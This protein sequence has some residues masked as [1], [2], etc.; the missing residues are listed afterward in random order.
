MIEWTASVSNGTEPEAYAKLQ[1]KWPQIPP[2]AEFEELTRKDADIDLF[3]WASQVSGIPLEEIEE[4]VWRSTKRPPVTL[5]STDISGAVLVAWVTYLG[6]RKVAIADIW[7]E[8]EGSRPPMPVCIMGPSL[9]LVHYD[10]FFRIPKNYDADYLQVLWVRKHQYLKLAN[11]FYEQARDLGFIDGSSSLSIPE[12]I[13]IA[14]F[15]LPDEPACEKGS[16]DHLRLWLQWA[17]TNIFTNNVDKSAISSALLDK[18]FAEDSLDDDLRFAW[19]NHLVPNSAIKGGIVAC[20]APE[21]GPIPAEQWLSMEAIPFKETSNTLFVLVSNLSNT[22]VDDNHFNTSNKGLVKLLTSRNS[23]V[24]SH[25]NADGLASRGAQQGD[26]EIRLESDVAFTIDPSLIRSFDPFRPDTDE[27]FTR[28]LLYYILHESVKRRASDIHIEDFRNTTRVRLAIDNSAVPLL[29]LPIERL[30]NIAALVKVICGVNLEGFEPI[31]ARFAFRVMNRLVDVRVS[32]IHAL[33]RQPK[34]TLRLLDKS[35]N[36]RALSELGLSDSDLRILRK[37]ISCPHG[38]ILVS[39][40]TGSGKSTTLYACI[41][42][43]NTPENII[44]TLEDP[45]E[46]E[47]PGIIQIPATKDPSRAKGETLLFSDGITK[48]L[49]AD[50]T[51]IMVGEIRDPETARIA[52]EAANTGHLLVST[53]HANNA[54]AVIARLVG[55]NV[56]RYVLADSIR[57]TVAQRLLRRLCSCARMRTVTDELRE[58]FAEYG[59]EIP[60]DKT[61]LSMPHGCPDCNQTGYRGRICVMEFLEITPEVREAIRTA[62]TAESLDSAAARS[63]YVPLFRKAIEKVWAGQTTLEEVIK[64]CGTEA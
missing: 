46:Y 49:R 9:T 35:M 3:E 28:L 4:F 63:G 30:S 44:Y 59:V 6:A 32:I 33:R 50:P 34:L 14:P 48:L 17:R 13:S 64:H 37:A 18:N 15:E 5:S 23:I 10:P 19:R 24:T 54:K 16:T 40:P 8:T 53:V 61:F 52:I 26:L 38:I 39:G 21:D 45:I 25:Q 51:V 22:D 2:F 12:G 47:M 58:Q 1:A 43:L 55:L 36:V 7:N 31:D 11:S 57:L 56:D 29:T 60:S 42:E 41:N 20:E 62:E 27:Q